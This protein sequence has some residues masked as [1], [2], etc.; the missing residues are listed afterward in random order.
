MLLLSI[1]YLIVLF[2]Y[3]LPLLT[4]HN[5]SITVPDVKGM[6]LDE[7]AATLQK[8]DLQ[9]HINDDI[10]YSPHYPPSVVLEQHPKPG[11][12]V[13]EG[14]R[15]Y[16]TL[17][18]AQAPEVMMPNL[19]D[20]SL[21]HAYIMLKSRGLSYNQITYVPDVARNAVIAQHYQGEPIL[22]DTPILQGSAID[23]IV[24]AGLR[25]QTT[26]VPDLYGILLDDAILMLLDVGLQPG[27]INYEASSTSPSKAVIQQRPHADQ[28]VK[29]GNRVDI[30]IAEKG[31]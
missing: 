27:T 13:K 20:S 7:L 12:H 11:T 26:Q 3:G 23:L 4:K 29:L 15:I 6:T 1:G 22:P 2:Q 28:R 17:N 14:R 21:R 8:R 31:D 18:A 9:Y 16:L 25:Q 30:W 24:G 5:Q 19:V 10:A